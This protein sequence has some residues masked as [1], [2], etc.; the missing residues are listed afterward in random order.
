MAEAVLLDQAMLDRVVDLLP[1]FS[2]RFANEVAL[3][4]GLAEVLDTDGISYVREFVAGPQD[5]FD[6]L[7]EPGIVIEAKIKGS[8]PQALRQ[9][10]RYA[11]RADVT[12]VLLVTTRHWGTVAFP[13]TLVSKAVRMVKVRGASF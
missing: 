6:F 8:M 11:A 10:G 12:A 13:P 4:E 7:I 9:I 5:R 2:Y 3:H 1:R